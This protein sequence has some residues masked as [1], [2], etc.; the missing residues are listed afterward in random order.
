MSIPY[1]LTEKAEAV[2]PATPDLTARITAA[3]D[4]AQKA[5]E[6]AK[7]PYG[8]DKREGPPWGGDHDW[9][10]ALSTDEGPHIALWSPDRVLAL[11]VADR[12]VLE[13]HKPIDF[14]V[15]SCGGCGFAWPCDD[16]L[17][18][19]ARWGVTT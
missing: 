2:L 19:A 4:E 18:L 13:R 3:M 14:G 5:S 16:Q 11:I 7:W 15:K 6:L 1:E 12:R 17:D 10:R 8:T 9:S